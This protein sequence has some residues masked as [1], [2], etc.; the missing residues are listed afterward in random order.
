MPSAPACFILGALLSSPVELLFSC[1]KSIYLKHRGTTDR[2]LSL[3][4]ES[5]CGTLSSWADNFVLSLNSLTNCWLWTTDLLSSSI[6]PISYRFPHSIQ[7]SWPLSLKGTA[8]STCLFPGIHNLSDSLQLHCLFMLWAF[9]IPSHLLDFRQRGP[10][11]GN[12]SSTV[13]LSRAWCTL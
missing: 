5:V 7:M 1:M 8:I 4:D 9:V 13:Y 12:K 2:P 3:N 10:S 6:F 11:S